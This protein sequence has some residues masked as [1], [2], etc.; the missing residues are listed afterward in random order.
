MLLILGSHLEMTTSAFEIS[1]GGAVDSK[2]C[3][4]D[5]SKCFVYGMIC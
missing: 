3:A 1:G 2:K 5:D 4:V